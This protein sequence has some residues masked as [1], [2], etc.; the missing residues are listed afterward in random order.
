MQAPEAELPVK[1]L[2]KQAVV[3]AREKGGKTAELDQKILKQT[4]RQRLRDGKIKKVTVANDVAVYC[5]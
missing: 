5:G 1:Q 3:A 2:V 4:L